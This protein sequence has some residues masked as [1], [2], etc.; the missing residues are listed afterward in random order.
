[1]QTTDSVGVMA[2]MYREAVLQG[3]PRPV[4][5]LMLVFGVSRQTIHRR[6]KE[7]RAQGLLPPVARGRKNSVAVHE[8]RRVRWLSN[9][10]TWLACRTCK[11]PWP[12]AE[13]PSEE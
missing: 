7:A 2:L 8:P 3:D 1:V 9:D 12:C 11:T 10:E 13:A 4:A 5:T 6:L